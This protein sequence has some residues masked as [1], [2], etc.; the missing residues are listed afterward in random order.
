MK[1]AWL[2][3]LTLLFI[4]AACKLPAPE[5]DSPTKTDPSLLF[6]SAAETADAVRMGKGDDVPTLP[7]D[8]LIKT[9]LAPT[10]TP[11]PAGTQLTPTNSPQPTNTPISTIEPA[12]ETDRAEFVADVNVP[13]GTT[14][15]PA[16]KF[17][18][19]WRLKNAGEKTWTSAYKVIFMEGDLLGA[20]ADFPMP[21]QVRPGE[22][23]DISLE[24]IA[25]TAPGFYRGDWKI[26]NSSGKIFGVG[27]D[28]EEPFWFDI[29]VAGLQDGEVSQNAVDGD[30]IIQGLTFS[31]DQAEVVSAD[32]PHT[33]ELTADFTVNKPGAVTYQLE[34]H[35]PNFAFELKLPPPQ[36]RN[37]KAGDH[38]IVY[39]LE[40]DNQIK[41]WVRFIII[42]P[43]TVKSPPVNFSLECQ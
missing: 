1:K 17:V 38:Q 24:L 29:V 2:V 13:D 30:G 35:T 14:V 7:P 15:Q 22:E 20:P 6:T 19:T 36:T 27:E 11:T 12:P 32:C 8:V 16:G 10:K 41:G 18:K 26:M 33:F 4:A 40:F 5:R 37:L 9:S 42:E 28:G 25:P 39:E 21:Q 23:V 34:A 43:E 3:L 31:V